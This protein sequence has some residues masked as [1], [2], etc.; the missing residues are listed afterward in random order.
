MHAGEPPATATA[1]TLRQLFTAVPRAVASVVRRRVGA[2]A[3][4]RLASIIP[5]SLPSFMSP[6]ARGLHPI[7]HIQLSRSCVRGGAIQ[8]WRH[9][10]NYQESALALHIAVVGQ[11]TAVDDGGC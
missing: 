8:L 7:G 10:S 1:S 11:L 5:A 6:A 9:M 4:L 3:V 2:P